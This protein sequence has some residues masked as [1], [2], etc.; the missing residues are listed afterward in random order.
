M[1]AI[2]SEDGTVVRIA[3]SDSS[4][5][6]RDAVADAE[7]TVAAVGS[8]GVAAV[9][10]LVAVTREGRTA[11]HAAPSVERLEDIAAALADGGIG[12][13]QADA[14]VD[15]DPGSTTLPAPSLGGLDVGRRR[16]LGGAGWRRPTDPDDHAAAGGFVDPGPADAM[17]VSERLRGR[18]WGDWCQ[19]VPVADAWRTAEAADGDATIVVNAHG[20]VADVRLLAIAPMDVLE[21][22][23]AAA[24]AVDA[25]QVVVY[26]AGTDE[27]AAG[28]AREAAANYPDP[29]APVEVVEGPD[30]YRAAEPTMVVEAL[31]GSD[32]LE[33]RLRPPGPDEV[34]LH[35]RPTLVHTPRTLAHLAVA[36][37]TD[38]STGSRLVT[39][40]GDVAA[41]ATVELPGDA[42]LETALSAVDV[43]GEFKAACVGGRFGGL[44]SSLDLPVDP[45]GLRDAG[46]GTEGTVEVL[47]ADSCVVEFVGKRARFAAA[48]N[49]GRCV[50]CREGSTQLADLLRDVYDGDFDPT[51]IEELCRVMTTSSICTFGVAA[52][53]P[54]RTAI[55]AFGGE[56][57][58]HADGRCP[59]GT[60][61]DTL[62]ASH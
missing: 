48:A 38:D 53:R 7:A 33:A 55:D 18:G 28:R 30:E 43:D 24:T 19:D 58:A 50:P 11:F 2:T 23:A 37:R 20:T 3:A 42:V 52:A 39:V 46:L 25:D 47:T 31:E 15:H 6:L 35:G 60:C 1:T 5:E 61:F 16:V 32:R 4:P 27:G 13:E 62:E 26:A 54:A 29:A 51:G 21:G 8:T 17:A 12:V 10:P 40:S 56:F 9:E 14:V 44:A 22:A 36:L 57:D 59:A 41:P 34:G 49:C 45:D